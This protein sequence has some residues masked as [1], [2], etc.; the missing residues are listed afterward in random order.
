VDST[1]IALFR[2]GTRGALRGFTAVARPTVETLAHPIEVVDV[3]MSVARLDELFRPVDVASV[4][5]LDIAH[6]DVVGLITRERFM[7]SMSG[8]LGY[9]RAVLARKTIEQITDWQPLVV[10]PYALVSEAAITAMSRT[11]ERRYDDV[12]VRAHVWSVVSTSDLVRSLSTV[13]AVRSLH[14]SLTGLANRDLVLRR[15]PAPALRR[16]GGHPRAG[17]PRPDGRRRSR[18]TERRS[19]RGHR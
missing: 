2:P 5:V 7:A 19:R 14:D 18:G 11:T 1:E 16:R 4:A 9:G 12:L 6:P 15:L 3:T 10:D 8:R 13:L 17:R